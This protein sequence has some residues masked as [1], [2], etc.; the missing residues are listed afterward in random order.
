[1]EFYL[2]VRKL[3]QLSIQNSERKIIS[4]PSISIHSTSIARK[5]RQGREGKNRKAKKKKEEQKK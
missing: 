5:K 3:R 4:I 1:M 2:V